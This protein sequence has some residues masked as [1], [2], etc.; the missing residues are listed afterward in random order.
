LNDTTLP[1]IVSP[2]PDNENQDAKSANSKQSELRNALFPENIQSARFT[3]T[4]GQNEAMKQVSGMIYVGT[5]H[6]HHHMGED[7]RV[8]W[9]KI[10]DRLYP[11]GIYEILNENY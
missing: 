5:H 7:G 4:Q 11:S 10:D 1:E 2:T 6:K 9:F 8:L 3:T